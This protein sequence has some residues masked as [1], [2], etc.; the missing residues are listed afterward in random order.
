MAKR[1]ILITSFPDKSFTIDLSRSWLMTAFRNRV[2]WACFNVGTNVGGR[3]NQI[4]ALVFLALRKSLSLRVSLYAND[5]AESTACAIWNITAD[6]ATDV[7][8]GAIIT[9]RCS[10][11]RAHRRVRPGRSAVIRE[12]NRSAPGRRDSGRAEL[13]ID[14]D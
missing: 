12:L 1:K 5:K 9:G 2:M 7:C 13:V 6:G 11:S 10:A 4:A 8:D 14:I 3:F